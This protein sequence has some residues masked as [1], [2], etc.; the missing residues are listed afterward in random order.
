MFDVLVATMAVA[1]AGFSLSLLL[2]QKPSSERQPLM[3]VLFCLFFLS[4]GPVIFELLPQIVQFYISF[5]PLAFFILLPSLWFYHQA[6]ISQRPWQ[7]DKKMWRHTIPLPFIGIFGVMLFLLPAEIFDEMFFSTQQKTGLDLA[8]VSASFFFA[9]LLWCGL[10]CVYLVRIA[11]LTKRY[12]KHVKDVYANEKGKRLGWLVGIFVLIVF[13]WVYAFVVLV[14]GD[15]LT[16]LGVSESG[17]I[18]L[19]TT[20]VWLISA[21]GLRQ[22]PGF[23]EE[24]P[25][26]VSTTASIKT[27][28]RVQ[29]T[30]E[31]SALTKSDLMQIA[32]KLKEAIHK[33]EMHLRDDLTLAKLS[34][35]VSVPPQYVSQTLSQGMETNFFDFINSARIDSAKQLL[36]DSKMSVLDIAMT[37]GF[38]SRSSFYK[39]FKQFAGETPS[40]Y[41]KNNAR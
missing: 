30:Y 26:D 11:M 22:R 41:R 12:H 16:T 20:I 40:H 32:D 2:I 23:E 4:T 25:P 8:I 7:W 13:T 3:S 18:V 29:N 39:A 35:C 14:V 24:S 15:R 10:S 27:E 19:L 36:I 28:T 6:L 17:V 31:R 1:V 5:L 38:N 21:N 9:V 33:E 37:T 34:E